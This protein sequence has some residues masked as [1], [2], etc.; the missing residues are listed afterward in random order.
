VPWLEAAVRD[1]GTLDEWAAAGAHDVLRGGRAPARVVPAP[2]SGPDVRTRWVLRRFRRGGI[3]APALGDRYLR[4]GEARP[5]TELRASVAARAR[6]VRTP[7]IVAGAMYP[8]GPFYRADLVTELVP[9]ARTLADSLFGDAPGGD[10]A[11]EGSEASRDDPPVDSRAALRAAGRLVRSLEDA[12]VLH[13][14]LNA[15]NILLRSVRGD[16]EPWVLDLDRCRVLSRDGPAPGAAMR[17]RLERSLRKLGNS[18][19][20]PLGSAE[21]E[22]LRTGCEERS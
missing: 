2:V 10:E 15:G 11:S 9:E 1:G 18:H 20:R 17:G 3:V 4:A 21:W 6:G 8:A 22:A 12:R 19:R 13:A 5:V 14:D 7:A 16:L